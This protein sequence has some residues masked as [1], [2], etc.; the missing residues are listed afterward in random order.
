MSSRR[1]PNSHSPITA[2]RS[3][4]LKIEARHRRRAELPNVHPGEHLWV[5]VGM[6]RL[7]DPANPRLDLDIENLMTIEGPGCFICE[8]TYTPDLAAEPCRGTGSNQ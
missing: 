7:A 1:K 2:V 5:A 4:G 6:W 3:T 8:E